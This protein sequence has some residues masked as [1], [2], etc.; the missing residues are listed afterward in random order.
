MS[1]VDT[2]GIEERAELI[3]RCASKVV[4]MKMQAPAIFALELYKPL[5][6]LLF[7]IALIASPAL[8]AIFGIQEAQSVAKLL[9]SADSIE[10]LIQ[11]I[12]TLS[13]EESK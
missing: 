8:V 9:Q 13:L 12:E 2:I 6:G 10:L 7:N 5:S 4:R 1:V 11:Q 3:N